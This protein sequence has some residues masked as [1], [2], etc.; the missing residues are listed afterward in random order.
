MRIGLP[1][2]LGLGLAIT[3]CA[4]SDDAADAPTGGTVVITNSADAGGLLPPI[5]HDILGKQAT[6]QIFDRLAEIGP[7]INTIGD[8]G[9]EPRLAERWEW[10]SDSLSIVFH[11]NPRARFHDGVP[12][13]A[14]DVRF[15]HG[16]YRNPALASPH[17]SMIANIDSITVR[18]SITVVAW[19][20]RRTPE[21]FFEVTYQLMILPEHLL[22][23]IPAADLGASDFAR[24]PVGSGRFRF[25]R[26][27]P[28]SSL[29]IVADTANYRGRS[30]LDR[31]IWSISPDPTA[32]VTKLLA[33]EADFYEALRIEQLADI[34]SDTNLRA[35][36]YPALAY[37][38]VGFNLT[39]PANRNRPHALF[40]DRAL[41]RAISMMV[42]RE[43]LVRSVFDTLAYVPRG[44]FA[45]SLG[46]ADTTVRTIPFDSVAAASTLDSLGWR[47]S[48]GDGIRDRNGRPL[49]FALL[50]PASSSF[51]VRLAVLLQEQLRRAGIDMTVD[52]VAF[53]V[54][55]QRQAVGRFD[56]IFGAWNMDPSPSGIRQTFTSS[57]AIPGGFNYGYYRSPAFDALIDSALTAMDPERSRSYFQRAYE[58]I[59]DD[60]IAIWMYELPGLAGVHR[61]IQITGM[62]PDAWWADLADWSI[63]ADQ[64]IDRDRI[65]LRSADR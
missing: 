9:F 58:T 41:R 30:K 43:Q 35:V 7:E 18:D 48:N 17:A 64:R 40:A 1:L 10:A 52:E 36:R 29:E 24:N 45:R 60:A 15:S 50:V 14:S 38:Y 20:G 53:S 37:A 56:A 16:L 65:G 49:R 32:A 54:M 26:W 55:A 25:A 5:V 8:E 33:G 34:A 11:L 47:D 12:V 2:A 51:R 6:D 62:R 61:R 3:A 23:D 22:K 19:F 13:R 27:T 28:G 57:G 21:Q 44:P 39:D 63:P 46:V 31:V 42:N 59:N 4:A